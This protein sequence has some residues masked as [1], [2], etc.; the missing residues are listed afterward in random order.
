M[1]DSMKNYRYFAY[2]LLLS[3]AVVLTVPSVYAWD[4]TGSTVSDHNYVNIDT[5]N[6][7]GYYVGFRNAGGGL[8]ALHITSSISSPYGQMSTVSSDS[9]TFYLADTGGRG[10]FDK[11]ILMVAIKAPDSGEELS[12]DLKIN[13]KA[14]GYR[15]TSS[16][17]KDQPPLASDITYARNSI[18]RSFGLYS[19]T[20]GPQSWKPAGEADHPIM[21]DQSSSD[22]FY[23]FFVDT[24][25]GV[26]GK[27]SEITGLTDNGMAKIEY[28]IENYNGETIVFNVYGYALNADAVQKG[29]AWTNKIE[30]TTTDK[31]SGTA[32]SGYIVLLGSSASPDDEFSNSEAIDY[33]SDGGVSYSSSE[34]WSPSVGNLNI[35]SEPAGAKIYI[36]GVDS[37]KITNATFTDLP[38]GDYMVRVDLEDYDPAENEVHVKAGYITTRNYNLTQASGRCTVLSDVRGARVYID[39]EETLC[40]ANWTFTDILTGNHTI[41]LKTTDGRTFSKEVYVGRDNETTVFFKTSSDD[42][43]TGGNVSEIVGDYEAVSYNSTGNIEP[44]PGTDSHATPVSSGTDT[45]ILEP[46]F[47]FITGIISPKTSLSP[48]ASGFSGSEEKIPANNIPGAVP[49]SV[50]ITDDS[51]EFAEETTN[52]NVSLQQT[53]IGSVY[54]TSYPKD[55]SIYIDGVDTDYTTPHLI[56]GLKKGYHKIQVKQ[57]NSFSDSKEVYIPAGEP[58]AV[59]FNLVD[60]DN[61]IV[62][63]SVSS[64]DFASFAVN[65]ELPYSDLPSNVKA[66]SFGSYLTFNDG[67]NYYSI[68]LPFLSGGESF[69]LN[70]GKNVGSLSVATDPADA[71]IYIDSLKTGYKTPC[72]LDNIGDGYHRLKVIKEGYLPA[73]KEILFVSEGNAVDDSYSFVLEEISTGNLTVTSDPPGCMIFLRGDYTGQV[74]PYTFGDIP[75]GTYDVGVM[76]NRTI[77]KDKEVTVQSS[78]KYG[79]TILNISL[80]VPH[81]I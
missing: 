59:Y 81:S 62:S 47:S 70:K 13:I 35:T 19:V 2:I 60:V 80:E 23:I 3:A 63:I 50:N 74:T 14:S 57:Q 16:G 67:E 22:E 65:G 56:Y 41:S 31:N 18:D 71:D 53:Q 78:K 6:G 28:S 51:G 34:V 36:D 7:A 58:T 15:W 4:F 30:G 64:R 46:F 54:V 24:G 43:S 45:G 61:Q 77:F 75:I 11:V 42:R 76:F 29:I 32:S 25:V 73:E 69:M 21:Y 12:E 40:Y 1:M 20:Y 17:V 27:N 9:G 39:D 52:E 49:E 55:M 48:A 5:A 66:E 68:T 26:L 8:N 79:D 38:A 10:Y 72:I 44:E 33:D 37:G